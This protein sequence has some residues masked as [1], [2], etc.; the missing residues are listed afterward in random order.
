ME[1]INHVHGYNTSSKG[2]TDKIYIIVLS[3]PVVVCMSFIAL[4]QISYISLP[5]GLVSPFVVRFKLG[6]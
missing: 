5:V 1:N 2:I 3:L 6:I 4:Y